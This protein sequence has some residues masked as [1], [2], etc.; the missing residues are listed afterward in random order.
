[1]FRLVPGV[2]DIVRVQKERR[3]GK[4]G[5]AVLLKPTWDHGTK[6]RLLPGISDIVPVQ[7]E[8]RRGQPGMAVLLK[9]TWDH[10]TKF[11]LLPGISD[12][13]PLQREKRRGQPRMAVPLNLRG[14]TAR[15]SGCCPESPISRP[16][17]RKGEED[18]QEWL[19]H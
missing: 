17:K 6:F 11:R 14:I 3:R 12:I 5:M 10:G 18:S 1:M 13:V 9:P 4:S 15:C 19:S 16:Y 7:K 2:S 8:R